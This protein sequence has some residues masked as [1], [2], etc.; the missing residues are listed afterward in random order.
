[1][2]SN[3]FILQTIRMMDEEEHE[4]TQMKER[5]QSRWNRTPSK[6]L[7]EQLRAEGAKYMS[8]LNNATK[9]DAIVKAKY[10]ENRRAMDILC[11]SAVTTYLISIHVFAVAYCEGEFFGTENTLKGMIGLGFLVFDDRNPNRLLCK[12]RFPLKSCDPGK[13]EFTNQRMQPV[14]LCAYDAKER[15]LSACSK[16]HSISCAA[17]ESCGNLA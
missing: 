8:I 3:L 16:I 12:D 7:T 17:N 5:F 4:D 9:A 2:I 10:N 1:M 14:T 6:Q 11:K 15:K 13:R